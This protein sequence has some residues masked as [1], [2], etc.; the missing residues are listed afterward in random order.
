MKYLVDTNILIDVADAVDTALERISTFDPGDFAMAALTAAELE[1][2]IV[3]DPDLSARREQATRP[4]LNTLTILPF[5]AA[6]ARRYGAI[7][8]ACGYNRRKAIDRMIAAT[9]LANGLTVITR[10][11]GDFADVFD[12]VIEDW[13]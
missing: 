3:A 6:I 7:V 5:D 4:L 11:P 13:S 9:A 10:N 1:A 12:L 2:S 8:A